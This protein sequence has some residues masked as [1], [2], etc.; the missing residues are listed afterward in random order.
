M[1]N[2]FRILG[3]DLKALFRQF[4][5]VVIVIAILFIPALYAWLNIYANWDPYGNTG[6]IPIAL[7]SYDLGYSDFDGSYVNKGEE[8]MAQVS[9]S[10]SIGWV[11]L[12][13]PDD[14]LQGVRDGT[15]YG[16]IIFGENF[17]RNMYDL[18]AALS[19]EHGTITF[20][21]NYKMNAV[22]NKISETAASTVAQNIQTAYLEV[23][24]QTIFGAVLERG[25]E[26]DA[27]T[28]AQNIIKV[29]ENLR[30]GARAGSNAIASF[31]AG[32]ADLAQDLSNTD[33]SA[34]SASLG[35]ASADLDSTSASIRDIRSAF[36]KQLDDISTRLDEI[37]AGWDNNAKPVQRQ[38]LTLEPNAPAQPDTPSEAVPE[39]GSPAENNPQTPVDENTVPS[40]EQL[41]DM[42]TALEDINHQLEEVR[43]AAGFAEEQQALDYM[44]AVDTVLA[45]TQSAVS[46]LAELQAAPTIPGIDTAEQLLRL[47]TNLITARN[48]INNTLRPLNSLIF[49]HFENIYES[50][51][52]VLSNLSLTVDSLN[53]TMHS[54][55]VTLDAANDTLGYVQDALY[56][57]AESLDELLEKIESFND[58]DLPK[59]LLELLRGSA[60]DFAEFFSCPVEVVTEVIYPIE[61]YGS[62]MTPFY[63][64]LAVWVGCVVNGAIIK[65]EA[66]PRKLKNVTEG[67]LYWSRFILLQIINQLQTLIIVL[68]DIYLLRC[69]CMHPFFFWFAFAVTSFT[70]TA[71]I[72]SMCLAFGDVGKAIVV[73]IM[74]LQIAGSS[75]TYPIE[76][77]SDIFIKL[78]RFFPFP[79]AINAV[80]E[81]MCGMYRMDYWAYL[82]QL[83]VFA[84]LGFLVG[85]VIRTPFIRI[86]EF[87]EEEMESSGVL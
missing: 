18:T 37:L 60:D 7:A 62:A 63:S 84:A 32:S 3:A 54:A 22:A 9:E 19:D 47:K 74:V 23:V 2:V 61:S 6:N 13:N 64:V 39:N 77:L 34:V 71:F 50:L 28:T 81:A 11:V 29:I 42:Q 49:D 44:Q 35:T 24:F 79:Y 83:L 4:F 33:T 86:N 31:R 75:G 66:S 1:L 68:G 53:P 56:N 25:Q 15:Y 69:Q 45:D 10:S 16:A 17:T 14:A 5:A 36:D 51:V 70:F 87:V 72:Y 20:Y 27:E 48:Y 59:S 73:V 55:A 30:N 78:Y 26:F 12:E 76:I 8:V 80:R 40:G 57:V 41:S 85:L 43:L 67:Q 38:Q 82:A 65:T 21:Q 52:P 46:T 58:S